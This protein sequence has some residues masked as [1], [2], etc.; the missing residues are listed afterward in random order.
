MPLPW[1]LCRSILNGFLTDQVLLPFRRPRGLGSR[2]CLGPMSKISILRKK[3]L[4]V[5]I[6]GAVGDSRLQVNGR[7]PSRPNGTAPSVQSRT[8]AESSMPSGHPECGQVGDY[9]RHS[10][11]HA[12]IDQSSHQARL[13]Q[14]LRALIASPL[15]SSGG[16]KQCEPQ[17]MKR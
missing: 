10:R 7:P 16:F 4:T 15:L 14:N 2:S 9:R 1:H 11:A 13:A 12:V 8:A 3:R 5:P 6:T 17:Y